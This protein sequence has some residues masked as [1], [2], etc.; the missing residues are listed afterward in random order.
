MSVHQAFHTRPRM[1]YADQLREQS[2][3][4]AEQRRRLVYMP[5][6]PAMAAPQHYRIAS[7][8]QFMDAGIFMSND[9]GEPKLVGK[10]SSHST[11]GNFS[12]LKLFFPMKYPI[13][14][15]PLF[16]SNS[17]SWSFGPIFAPK[18]DALVMPHYLFSFRQFNSVF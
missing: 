17:I 14:F 10:P 9:Q 8:L 12:L 2:Q 16:Q 7:I 6:P 5:Q 15:L 1:S 13:T 18:M 4:N 3:H 11:A